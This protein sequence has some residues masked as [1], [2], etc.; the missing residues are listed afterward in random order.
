MT[1]VQTARI[2][3]QTAPIAVMSPACPLCHTLDQTVTAESLRAGANWVC[4]RCGQAWSAARLETAAAY[5]QY[6]A[7]H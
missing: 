6:A 4:T 5:T 3:V 2:P 1:P 7:L